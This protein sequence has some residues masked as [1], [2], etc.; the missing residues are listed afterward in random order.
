MS[1]ASSCADLALA[2]PVDWPLVAATPGYFTFD[3]DRPDEEPEAVLAW[4]VGPDLTLPVTRRGF[5]SRETYVRY[6]D[7][8]MRHHGYKTGGSYLPNFESLDV[9]RA[10][11]RRE[12]E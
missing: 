8:V 3:S 11:Q 1:A 7:G 2:A 10:K 6:P 9:W 12:N 5:S 4:R